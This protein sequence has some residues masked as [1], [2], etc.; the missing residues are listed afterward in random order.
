MDALFL[1]TTASTTPF[2]EYLILSSDCTC[3]SGGGS[4]EVAPVTPFNNSTLGYW[5]FISGGANPLYVYNAVSL[6]FNS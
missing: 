2:P 6:T 5:V 3:T 1:F 4:V